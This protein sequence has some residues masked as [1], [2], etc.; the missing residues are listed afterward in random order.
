[1]SSSRRPSDS[2]LALMVDLD[3][4]DLHTASI[5]VAETWRGSLRT[6]AAN[7]MRWPPRSPVPKDRVVFVMILSNFME[8]TSTPHPAG[9]L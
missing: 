3:N 2:V 4:G 8:C 5:L 1:M 7:T 6:P 9:F